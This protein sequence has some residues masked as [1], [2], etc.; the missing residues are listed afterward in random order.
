MWRLVL[1]TVIVYYSSSKYVIVS[2]LLEKDLAAV[3][4]GL[5]TIPMTCNVKESIEVSPS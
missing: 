1:T 3:G 5:P 4:G 2:Y